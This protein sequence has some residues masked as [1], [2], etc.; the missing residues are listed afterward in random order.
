MTTKAFRTLAHINHVAIQLVENNG[1]K[2]VPLK[3]LCDAIGIDFEGQ[4]QRIERDE[5]LKSIA[6]I[7][8][9]VAADE[10]ERE[11][12]CLPFK[13]VFGWLFTIDAGRVRED[14]REAVVR[15]QL[16]CYNALYAYHGRLCFGKKA[17][18]I[19]FITR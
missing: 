4:R 2:W 10:K 1:E 5:I 16:Q 17:I 18:E 13:F 12:L 19:N 9:A 8:K 11:M 3:P 7:I 6:F 15:Y 14:I